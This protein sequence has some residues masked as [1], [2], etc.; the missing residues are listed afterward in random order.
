MP[1]P[2]E[3]VARR[4]EQRRDVALDELVLQRERRGRHHDP[5]AV[6][7]RRARGSPA[8]C[9]CRCRPGR[10][11][12]AG[13]P[14]PPRPPPPSRSGPG[15]PRRRAAR[16]PHRAPRALRVGPA[17]DPRASPPREHPMC[18]P[19]HV[20]R[21]HTYREFVPRGLMLAVRARHARA[22]P[23]GRGVL[24]VATGAVA[25]V[26]LLVG[27]DSAFTGLQDITIVAAL[28]FVLVMVALCVALLKDRRQDP[29]MV[30]RRYAAAPSSRPSSR[31]SPATATTSRSPSRRRT[32]RSAPE[33]SRSG[34]SAPSPGPRGPGRTRAGA[35]WRRR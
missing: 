29:L 33:P 20:V 35:R 32:P 8:T 7:Q 18:S 10:A 15:A 13:P 28:P 23:L 4:L 11:G 22:Q 17:H 21:E 5:V 2:A 6:Q 12:A 1:P 26:M 34:P 30:R 16:R 19:G 14:S 31:G 24:G 25:A 27:G 9:R 3:P